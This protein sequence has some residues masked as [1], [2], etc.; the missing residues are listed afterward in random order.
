MIVGY[1]SYLPVA[2]F[3]FDNDTLSQLQVTELEQKPSL[4]HPW[5]SN[6]IY[7][8]SPEPKQQGMVYFRHFLR[9]VP[10]HSALFDFFCVLFSHSKKI[11]FSCCLGGFRLRIAL[12][13]LKYV[14][15]FL[16]F[17]LVFFC[18]HFLLYQE[19]T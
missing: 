1:S 10:G 8:R 12:N 13:L 11:E 17:F 5:V 9:T 2:R 4:K 19:M 7:K 6:E 14:F 18:S 15:I 3:S 16:I